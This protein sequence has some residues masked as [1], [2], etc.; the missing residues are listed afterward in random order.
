MDVLRAATR[1]DG[2]ERLVGAPR[3]DGVERLVWRHVVMAWTAKVA[4]RE[5]NGGRGDEA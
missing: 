3:G 5:Q 4:R 1:G 2:V